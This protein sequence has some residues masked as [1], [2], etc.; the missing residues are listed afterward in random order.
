MFYIYESERQN[1][2]NQKADSDC[3]LQ[4]MNLHI[5]LLTTA[6]NSIMF[7]SRMVPHIFG[8]HCDVL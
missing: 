7:K 4:T 6:I 8:G 1:Q 3:D 5:L 2:H